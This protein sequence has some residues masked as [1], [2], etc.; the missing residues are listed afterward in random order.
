VGFL[1]PQNLIYGLS[2]ALL[3]VIY[4]RSRS[5]PT[6]EVSSLMLFDEAPAPVAN[7][8]HVRL[9]PLFWLETAVLAALTLAIAGLYIRTAPGPGH[10]RSHALI[11]D[12]GAGMSA[13]EG[14]T[15]RLDEARRTALE[16]INQS[17][18]GDEF[19][20]SGYALEAQVIHP[21]TS[22]LDEVR[23]ALATLAP[24]AVPARTAALSAALMRARGAAVI[25]LFADRTPPSGILAEVASSAKVNFHLV[26]SNA[27]NLAIVSLDSGVPNSTKGHATIRN[28]GTQPHICDLSIELNDSPFF[29][30]NLML[31]PRE[32]IVVPFGPLLAGGTLHARILTDDAIDA[33][34]SRYAY[35]A[36]GRPARML[37][38]SPDASVRDDF[39]R[40]LLAVD[41]NF[42]I[43]TAD[44]AK[45]HPAPAANGETPKPFE[46]VVM[47]DYFTDIAASSTLLIYP[48]QP[49]AGE[50]APYNI[51]VDAT[52]PDAEITDSL[53]DVSSGA[54]ALA[55]ESTRIIALP[56]WIEQVASASSAGRPP[57][58]AAAVGRSAE[59][60]VGVIAF[61]IRNHL[62]LAPDHL[63]ALVVSVDMVK[64]LTEPHKVQIV[65]TGSYLTVPAIKL[66]K[67]S[68]PDGSVREVPADKWGR[69]R[70]R[71]MQSG[72]YIVESGNF[73]TE[74]LA[75]YFD[76]TESDLAT[77]R[78]ATD[79]SSAVSAIPA[80]TNQAREVRPL[81]I[82][83]AGIALLALLI[84]SVLLIR[85]AG[86]WGMRH[87]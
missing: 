12:L 45:Y 9:D 38:L 37:V 14:S 80:A 15:T 29:H 77:R 64:Q 20:V 57:F 22:N 3:V 46:L 65:S 30:Q 36:S 62:L 26:G 19:S 27:P 84:E 74:V 83:L 81:L 55:L 33:D 68:Q 13:R 4:L 50:S 56:D 86:W 24:M 32:Q 53:L 8:R 67:V 73:K 79:T 60:R 54:K 82:A 39:A 2:V 11:F 63:D 34:N 35:A 43:E 21:Q 42:Q 71:P 48:P 59:G 51:K 61:D 16:I 44:P 69:A 17:P 23:K 70:I 41:A 1:N 78:G 72:R 25:D 66:A 10:G 49:R 85:H 31:A 76:A 5:R 58:P 40:V 47:H 18:V 87:V 28:F 52:V 75:N 6:I 7:V